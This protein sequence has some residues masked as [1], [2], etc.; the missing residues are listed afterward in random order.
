MRFE[1]WWDLRARVR[2]IVGVFPLPET[3]AG[4]LL[5]LKIVL[6]WPVH[7]LVR[8]LEDFVLLRRFRSFSFVGRFGFGTHLFPQGGQCLHLVEDSTSLRIRT[9]FQKR[10]KSGRE[11]V[12]GV[13]VSGVFEV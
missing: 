10:K 12:L 9:L 2:A 11:R 6:H 13:W 7:S 4:D 3:V 1:I 8:L 5:A